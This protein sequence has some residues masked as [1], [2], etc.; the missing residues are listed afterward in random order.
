MRRGIPPGLPSGS[1]NLQAPMSEKSIVGVF[2]FVG[3]LYVGLQFTILGEPKFRWADS[4]QEDWDIYPPA[5]RVWNIPEDK[6]DELNDA[7]GVLD[8][9]SR[10]GRTH[11]LEVPRSTQS[12]RHELKVAID[13]LPQ[14]VKSILRDH[15]VG[16]HVVGNLSMPGMPYISGLAIPQSGTF[17]GNDGTTSVLVDR[18]YSDTGMLER[19]ITMGL[20]IKSPDQRYVILARIAKKGEKER[21]VML[22]YLLLHE[23]G[24][25]VDNSRSFVSDAEELPIDD[26]EACGFACYS[27]KSQTAPKGDGRISEVVLALRNGQFRRMLEAAPDLMNAIKQSNFESLYSTSGPGEDF[28]ENFATYVHTIIMG[29]PW[30]LS[31][32][33][34]G[35]KTDEMTSCHLDGRCPQK[36]A[37]FDKLFNRRSGQGIAERH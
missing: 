37:F 25:V 26:P 35:K 32:F 19:G 24:H 7:I 33:V 8:P 17:G 34:E 28:A 15:L 2:A 9:Q 6:L 14:E 13:Q 16:V 36:T 12:F 27:W 18:L 20:R 5:R 11:K 22:Q 3:L 30:R 31:L 10:Y 23:F 1:I 4:W 29:R 21:F